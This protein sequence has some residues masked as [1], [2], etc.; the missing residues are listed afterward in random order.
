VE[1]LLAYIESE[2]PKIKESAGISGFTSKWDAAELTKHQKANQVDVTMQL[3]DA[4]HPDAIQRKTRSGNPK[5]KT[6]KDQ[7][8]NPV[9][10]LICRAHAQGLYSL[11]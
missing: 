11:S 8:L 10:P 9:V 2:L 7:R 5:N 6:A 4:F 1:D 3:V